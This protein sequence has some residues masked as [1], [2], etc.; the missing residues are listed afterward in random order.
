MVALEIGLQVVGG[1]LHPSY[2]LRVCRERLQ[3]LRAEGSEQ[4]DGIA[5]D[6]GPERG[7]ESREQLLGRGVPAPAQVQRQLAQ[8]G[9]GLGQH[10]ADGEP[11]DGLHRREDSAGQPMV[12]SVPV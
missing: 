4:L 7:I 8:G 3:P 12:L 2:D 6:L 1:H 9:K 10:G 11:S 5:T